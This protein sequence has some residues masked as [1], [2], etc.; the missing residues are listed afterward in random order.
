MFSL[1]LIHTLIL[2]KLYSL[3]YVF[4]L[5]LFLLDENKYEW[6]ETSN[7]WTKMKIQLN[8]DS[9]DRLI[10]FFLSFIRSE[11]LIKISA[12][13]LEKLPLFNVLNLFRRFT[14]IFILF[15]ARVDNFVYC[16]LIIDIKTNE[17]IYIQWQVTTFYW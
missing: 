12:Q 8:I 4:G 6:K 15:F 3:E 13:R 1:V 5:F 14:A 10:S 7:Q 2:T 9:P 16:N 11:W 17:M